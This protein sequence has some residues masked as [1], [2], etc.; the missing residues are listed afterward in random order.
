[1]PRYLKS[2]AQFFI[3]IVS[4]TALGWLVI[5]FVPD[6]LEVVEYPH[7]VIWLATAVCSIF[8][9]CRVGGWP[10]LLMVVGSVAYFV[11]HTETRFVAYAMA[12]NWK[13]SEHLA[14]WEQWAT[15]DTAFGVAVLCFP[16]GFSWY[17][18]RVVH[19]P[20]QALQPTAGRSDVQL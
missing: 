1:M 11:M 5:T 19:R 18:L 10:A 4:S 9:F 14:F 2:V 20:N 16:I 3:V 6:G 7:C 15:Y 17:V 12:H 8:F 13:A